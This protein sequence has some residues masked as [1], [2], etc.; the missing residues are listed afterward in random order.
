MKLQITLLTVLLL[1]LPA[2]AAEASKPYWFK[3]M[4]TVLPTAFCNSGQY[5][6]PRSS[7]LHPSFIYCNSQPA[8]RIGKVFLQNVEK[9]VVDI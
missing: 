8:T 2:N 5:F 4:S 6:R 9:I 1:P 3:S 7:G